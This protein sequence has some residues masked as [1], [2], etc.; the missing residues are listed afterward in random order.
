MPV[1]CNQCFVKKCQQNNRLILFEIELH[2]SKMQ[3]SVKCS[4][5]YRLR[6]LTMDWQNILLVFSHTCGYQSDKKHGLYN[7]LMIKPRFILLIDDGHTRLHTLSLSIQREAGNI[8]PHSHNQVLFTHRWQFLNSSES[9]TV[10]SVRATVY[11]P[12]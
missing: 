12:D 3:W 9:H 4:E 1:H 6:K 5:V 11:I 7:I 2:S 8:W 10:G